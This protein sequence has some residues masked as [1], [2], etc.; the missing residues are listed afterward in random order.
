LILLFEPWNLGDAIIAASVARLA[1]DRFILACNSRWHEVLTLAS[2]G[3]LNL[4][5]LNLPYVWRTDKKFFSL[6]DAAATVAALKSKTP[7]KIE[8]VSIRGDIRDWVAA[9]RLFQGT[10]FKFTGWLPF[11]ARKISIFDLPFK[12]GYLTLRNRYRAWAE[13]TGISFGVVENAYTT[14]HEK[15]DDAPVMIHV[16]AQWRSKQYPHVAELAELLKSA[17]KRVEILAGP[18]DSLPTGIAAD[19]VQR[20]KWP[21]LVAHLRSARYVVTNDSGPMH[22]AAYLGCRTLAL[23]RCSNITEWLPPG[24]TALSSPSAPRG[25]RPVPDYW[26]DRVL[27]NWTS[28]VEVMACLNANG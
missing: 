8:V 2:D 9:H 21:E 1:P 7:Q 17:G 5:P 19:M 3:S 13:A 16:G 4:L 28:P 20:P 22:L 18:S 25:Y 24:V 11:C 15:R 23:S 27:P 14:H 12:H 26:S 6:G 10:A